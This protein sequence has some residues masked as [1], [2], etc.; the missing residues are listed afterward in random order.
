MS[1]RTLSIDVKYPGINGIGVIH[2][3]DQERLPS[4]LTE[5][6]RDRPDYSIHPA[7]N[8][9]EYWPIT[10]IEPLSSNAAAVGLDMAHETNRYS[11]ARKARDTGQAQLTWPIVLVQDA[12]KTPGFLFYAPFY[13]GGR[14]DTIKERRK[15]FVGLVYAPFVIKKLV[16]GTLQKSKRHV[17]IQILDGNDT[18]YDE[19]VSSEVDYDPDPLFNSPVMKSLSDQSVSGA[20]MMTSIA[21]LP[22]MFAT[23][24]IARAAS[25]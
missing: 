15:H 7:H 23:M 8:V 10:Y 2:Y 9:G 21:G 3:I 25:N 17:G 11:A 5:Q 22:S 24:A 18:L 12:E 16:Q 13:E 1:G 14:Y 20:T 4:Y 19:H 6:R